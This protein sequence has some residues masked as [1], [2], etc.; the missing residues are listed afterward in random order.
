M[1]ASWLASSLLA[2]SVPRRVHEPIEYPKIQIQSTQL[3]LHVVDERPV[4]TTA[5]EYVLPLPGGFEPSARSRLQ[6]LLGGDGPALDVLVHV[7][8]ADDREITDARGEMTRILV[9]LAVDISIHEGPVLR[10]AETQ[11]NSDLARDEATPDEVAFLLDVT[12]RD[13]FDRYFSNAEMLTRLNRDLAAYAQ[14]RRG[15][16]SRPSASAP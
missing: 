14:T 7:L 16:A 13:A 10:H 3:G 6:A 4:P 11:S 8:T 15:G 9:K 1:V 12:L 2:C 5:A